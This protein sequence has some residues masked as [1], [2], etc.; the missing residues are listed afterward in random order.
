MHVKVFLQRK[1]PKN[2]KTPMLQ[3]K[4]G[5]YII[6]D[7]KK[8]KY[9]ENYLIFLIPLNSKKKIGTWTRQLLVL[10]CSR[11]MEAT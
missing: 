1:K 3:Q 11:D 6:L 2:V 10:L 4:D 5:L 7:V 8:C 9:Q